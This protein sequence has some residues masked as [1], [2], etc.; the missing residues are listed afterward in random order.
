[1][2]RSVVLLAVAGLALQ[3][4]IALASDE[5][6]LPAECSS[7]RVEAGNKVSFHVYARGVQIYR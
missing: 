7:I 4:S 6:E 5:P 1:M 2:V 3:P